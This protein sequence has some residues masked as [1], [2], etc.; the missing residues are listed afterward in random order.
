MSSSLIAPYGATVPSVRTFARLFFAGY[1]ALMAWEI[2][3]RTIT[4]WVVGGPLEPPGL[5][6][7]LVQHWTGYT[8]PLS[9]ATFLHYMVGILGYPLA[10]LVISRHLR[11][12]SMIL[13]A[14]VWVI[15]TL[16]LV[17]G[18][19]RGSVT[20]WMGAFWVVVTLITASRFWNPNRKIAQSISW[21]SF[22]WFNALGIMAPLAGLPFLLLE[23]GGALS[24]MSYV[25]HILFGFIIAYLFETWETRAGV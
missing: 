11:Y 6:I 21:G 19:I 20:P 3:A 2:W 4:S 15:F 17:Y 5:I 24:F 18:L 16:F 1:C 25:G 8:L 10:Y 9:T 23:W 7:S 14:L 22:T 13:D 12:W